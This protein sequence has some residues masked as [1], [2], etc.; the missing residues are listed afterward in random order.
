[1]RVHACGRIPFCLSRAVGRGIHSIF[2][3]NVLFVNLNNRVLK[4]Y[5]NYF[6]RFPIDSFQVHL[7]S[8]PTSTVEEQLVQHAS[9]K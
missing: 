6:G 9:I 7:S 2:Q 1:M 5:V 8:K 4:R 3:N